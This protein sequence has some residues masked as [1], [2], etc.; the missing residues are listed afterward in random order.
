MLQGK[1]RTA[2][3]L[4]HDGEWHEV[5]NLEISSYGF[6]CKIPDGEKLQRL[7]GRVESLYGV[8]GEQGAF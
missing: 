6:K 2:K 5:V 1:Y 4:L 8:I 7:A 3:I